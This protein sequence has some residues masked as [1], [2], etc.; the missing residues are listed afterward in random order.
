[1]VGCRWAMPA[2][3]YAPGLATFGPGFVWPFADGWIHVLFLLPAPHTNL[4]I[5]RLL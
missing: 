2:Q 4:A 3:G 1:M 5:G